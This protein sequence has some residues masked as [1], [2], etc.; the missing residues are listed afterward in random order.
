MNKR[1]HGRHGVWISGA[2]LMALGVG[3]AAG[4]GAT[5]SEKELGAD[6]GPVQAASEA[7]TSTYDWPQFGGDSRHGGNNTL[8]TKITRS[9]VNKLAQ[10]FRISLP[11][12]IEGAP[13]VLTN[14]TTPSGVHDVGF[15]T[16]R[17]GALV[18]FD[19][20]TGNTLWTKQPSGS[21]ITMSS[22]AI[23]PSR[24]YV[25]GVGLDMHLHKYAVGDG[26]EVLTGGWPQ[27][28][29]NKPSV[30]KGSTALTIATV[31]GV[32][33][34]YLG[35]GGYDGDG[36]D[37]QGHVTTVNLNT[38]TETVFN[39]MCSDQT[40][41]FGTSPDC[42]AA[43]SGIWAKAGVTFDPATNRL[44]AVTGNG[45]Y[46]PASRYWGDSIL[47]LSPDGTGANGNPLDT[48]TPSN[49]Q[50]LQNNDK[51]LGSTN[52]L[53]LPNN[54]SKY[55]HLGAMS[56]KDA[57]VRL[58][59]LDN[60][61]GQGGPG[62]V[63]GEVASAALTTGGEN[64]NPSTSWINPADGSTWLFFVSPANGINAYHLLVDGSGNPALSPIWHAGG[65]GGGAAVANNVLYYATNGVLHALDPL[66]GA[67]LWRDS[68][69]GQIHWQTPAIVN[70]VVYIGDNARELTAYSINTEQPLSRSGWTA[71]G[72]P[73]GGDVAANA[74]DGNPATRWSTGAAMTN[75]MSFVVDMKNT[76]SFDEISMLAGGASD[77]PRSFQV[78]VSN[79]GVN[80]GNAITSGTGGGTTVTAAFPPQSARFIKV[81]Q[82][83]TASNWWSIAEFNVLTSGSGGGGGGTGGSSG[84]G[85]SGGGG[86]TGGGG[87]GGSAGSGGSSG[88]FA[89][90]IDCGGPAAAPY[91]ADV[92]FTGGS[93]INHASTIDLSGVTN[94]APA[95]VYQSGRIGN[96][97]YTIPGFAPNS[98]HTVRLHFAETYFSSA[99]SR[100]FNVSINGTAELS[101]F[102]IESAAGAKNKAI[103]RSFTLNANASG[104][105]VIQTQSIKDNSL[106]SGVDIQ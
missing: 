99:G 55:P 84:T 72:T 79:D 7:V 66:T 103:T 90:A 58:I 96:F 73:T 95:A 75:G 87:T 100:V 5:K 49:Y 63:A 15:V 50:T 98:S 2:A 46:A 25:Y 83:G 78:F 86:V 24:A 53:I 43:K 9:N 45:T 27:L 60:M 88:A 19:A 22:P 35:T 37:Y 54:G 77:Y 30:E 26:T 52:L 14:V 76:Q 74:L 65:G 61:S 92:D 13:V 105:Y 70:G 59:N 62:H 68:T 106:I 56:G 39:A 48:Y 67:E 80:F 41:H 32:S 18:A 8:E 3:S 21:Q 101:N 71:V 23:D 20:Y 16:T 12:T 64:Q 89:S 38:G 40:V 36:G 34:L 81:V 1:M 47:A 10:L 104:A 29:T 91:V 28:F 82:T 17:N 11:E 4:C 94:P 42:A 93:T 57:M 44:Y 51:D 97:S 102:D 33:Y 85:G 31:N 69:I 6:N